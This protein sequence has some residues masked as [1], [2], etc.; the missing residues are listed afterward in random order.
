[1]TIQ[2]VKVFKDAMC[3]NSDSRRLYKSSSSAATYDALGLVV[4]SIKMRA[5]Y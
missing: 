3:N 2:M 4:N 1:M 5:S